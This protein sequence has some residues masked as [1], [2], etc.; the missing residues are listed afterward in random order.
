VKDQA[1][2]YDLLA[3]LRGLGVKL[4]SVNYGERLSDENGLAGGER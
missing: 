3:R 4:L 2:L 1:A